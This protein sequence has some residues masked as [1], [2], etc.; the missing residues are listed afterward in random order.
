MQDLAESQVRQGHDVQVF[1]HQHVHTAAHS[2]ISENVPDGMPVIHRQCSIGPVLHTPIM[3]RP[4]T[5]LRRVLTGFIPDVVHVHWPNPVVLWLLPLFDRLQAPLVVQWHSDTV[6]HGVSPWLKGAHGVLR[7]WENRLLN[8]AKA[9]VCSSAAYAESSL[10][11]RPF[12]N[13][14]RVIPLGVNFAR[15]RTYET[16]SDLNAWVAGLW[17]ENTV[18]LLSLGRLSFYKN[19]PALVRL[20][21]Q[22]HA[23]SGPPVSLV[24]AGD[25]PQRESL[26][27]LIERLNLEDQ[28]CLLGSVDDRQAQ[29]LYAR[30]HVFSLASNDRAESFGLVLLEALFHGKPLLVADTPGSGMSAV[31]EATQGG[32]LFDPASS[33]DA[34]NKLRQA[35]ALADTPGFSQRARQVVQEHFSI[36]TVS[37]QWQ[38]LY[39]E[40]QAAPA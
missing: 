32:V 39:H 21:A 4:R 3:R 8:Q 24:I 15:L 34:L 30:S 6:T 5:A 16:D 36:Q 20:V 28:V 9:V 10:L 40:I 23:G 14:I 1:C 26:R 27:R 19:L 25:G 17:S 29:A 2:V 37:H 7:V 13:K 38:W 22:T 35:R 11:L 33:A 31:V 18:R 12:R